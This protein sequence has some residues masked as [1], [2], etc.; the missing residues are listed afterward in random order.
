MDVTEAE[1]KSRLLTAGRFSTL[2]MLSAKALRIYAES[3]LLP[4]HWVDPANAYRYYHPDQVGTG[5]LIALLRGADMPLEQIRN[6]VSCDGDE[7]LE[8]I[9]A[10]EMSIDRRTAA[11]KLVLDRAR[12]RY[13]KDSIMDEITN[14][15]AHDQP[16]M[17]MLRRFHVDLIDQV[18]SESL[19]Q[20]REA[21]GQAGLTESA[22]P[23]GIFHSPIDMENDGPL[24][25]GIV[26]DRLAPTAGDVRSYHLTGGRIATRRISG[27]DTDWPAILAHYDEVCA[28]ID[29]QGFTRVGPPRE[30]WH[31]QNPEAPLELTIAWPYAS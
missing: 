16:V 5:W 19:G 22:D 17:T 7:A 25:I 15:L 23:F 31:R 6:L 2:T 20:L 18:I 9:D 21:A 12:Q 13:R 3:G 24:E 8:V 29:D 14:T 27:A 1:A 28:W 11:S 26:V 30:I 4:P 10:Y